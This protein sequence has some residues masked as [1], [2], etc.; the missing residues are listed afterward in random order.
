[1]INIKTMVCLLIILAFLAVYSNARTI[2]QDDDSML[3][4]N[5]RRDLLEKMLRSL[6]LEARAFRSFS[7]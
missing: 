6:L 5:E 2:E 4:G 1:M 7:A 3:D